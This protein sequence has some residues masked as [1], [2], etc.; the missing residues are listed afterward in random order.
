MQQQSC[1]CACLRLQ[2][3]LTTIRP[4]PDDGEGYRGVAAPKRKKVE[5]A[6]VLEEI[7]KV[8]PVHQCMQWA[9]RSAAHLSCGNGRARGRVL[10]RLGLHCLP[11]LAGR[12]ARALRVWLLAVA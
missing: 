3:T 6:P 2:V 5:D 12:G 4:R 8:T 7:P 10:L 1:P 11:A 9:A